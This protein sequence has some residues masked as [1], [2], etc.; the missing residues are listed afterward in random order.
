MSVDGH[1]EQ[2]KHGGAPVLLQVQGQCEPF[3]EGRLTG[4]YQI[5]FC[6]FIGC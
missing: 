6:V 4:S 3:Y 1:E 5:I 2:G